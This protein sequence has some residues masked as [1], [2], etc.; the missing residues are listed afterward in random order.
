MSKNKHIGYTLARNLEAAANRGRGTSKRA[1]KATGGTSDKIYSNV[2]LKGYI[3]QGKAF[4]HWVQANHP[5]AYRDMAAAEAHVAE[6]LQGISNSGSRMA[7]AAALAKGF[8]R[9][10]GGASWGV[11]LGQR[12]LAQITRGRTTTD[13]AAAFA[14]N[15]PDVCE[16]LRCCGLRV[17]EAQALRGCD[18]YV[19]Q[20]DGALVAH[21][22]KG[23]GGRSREAVVWSSGG[24]TAGRDWLAAHAQS[25]GP[26]GKVF[27]GYDLSHANCHAMRADYAARMYAHY[28]ASSAAT[29]QMYT[30]RDGSATSWDK[31]ALDATSEV[32]GHGDRRFSTIY[33]NY[34]SYGK[35]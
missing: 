24:N 7:A 35:A 1:A 16:A 3:K 6:Y 18:V 4:A 23:K 9:D 10:G 34:L 12:P 17:S 13:R 22:I 11:A 30:P 31:G 5:D 14:Q 25:A 8:G 27:G 32:L 29:G 2:T 28:A 20:S 15:H 26:G 33:Y 19:R 21:V